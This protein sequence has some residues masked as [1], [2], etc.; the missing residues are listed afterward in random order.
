MSGDGAL[1]ERRLITSVARRFYLD[2]ISKVQIGQEFGLSRFKVARLLEQARSTGIVTITLDDGGLPDDPLSARLREH[3]QLAECLVVGTHGG[4]VEARRQ[5]GGAAA[6]LL[7]DTLG[8]GDV[9]GLAWGRTITAMTTELRSLPPVSI[10]Q[11]TGVV[12]ADLTESPVEV[13]RRASRRAGGQAHAIFA[14]LLL[15]DAATAAGLRRQPDVAQ[16]L[17]LFSRIT[18]AFVAVGSWDPPISQLREVMTPED[19]AELERQG[20]QAEVAGVLI[21]ADGTLVGREMAERCLSITAAQLAAVPRVVAVAAGAAKAAAVMA[22]TRSG[23]ISALVVD[24]ALAEALLAMPFRA[25][26]PA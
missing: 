25:D 1:A 12:G 4:D 22:V 15:H 14:P 5:V 8:D 17:A 26:P 11:L 7:T 20:V 6:A 23:L 13:V 9:L 24:R 18:V 3:L 10:V 2:D 16:A 19:R 21:D